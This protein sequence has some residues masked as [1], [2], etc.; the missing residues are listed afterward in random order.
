M[1]MISERQRH[2][3]NF[4]RDES[5]RNERKAKKRQ[6]ENLELH[7]E[8]RMHACG[9]GFGMFQYDVLQV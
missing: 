1:T 4:V 6:H 2:E 5:Y 3:Q 8:V 7:V 9:L